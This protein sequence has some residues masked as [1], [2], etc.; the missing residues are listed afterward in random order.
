MTLPPNDSAILR[1]SVRT[2]STTRSS[3]SG[4]RIGSAMIKTS[5]TC[6]HA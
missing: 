3:R 2:S 1:F 4:R 5:V 6:R